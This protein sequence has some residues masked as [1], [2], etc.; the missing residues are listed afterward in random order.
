MPPWLHSLLM[1][2]ARCHPRCSGHLD[3]DRHNGSLADALFGR[4][5]GPGPARPG[6][7]QTRNRR[8]TAAHSNGSTQSQARPLSK[9]LPVL[10]S[11]SFTNRHRCRL[12]EI[13]FVI[14]MSRSSE[15]TAVETLDMYFQR[16][17]GRVVG[18]TFGWKISRHSAITR[19]HTLACRESRPHIH[20][21]RSTTRWVSWVK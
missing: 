13:R 10:Y 9:K 1:C 6:Q 2:H 20:P 16:V 12:P 4:S 11:C 19:R 3:V 21:I 8:P 15:T 7:T 17:S 14:F 5:G 18:G